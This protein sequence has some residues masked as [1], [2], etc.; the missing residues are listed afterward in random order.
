MKNLNKNFGKSYSDVYDLIYKD[1]NYYKE[2]NLISRLVVKHSKILESKNLLD[3]GCGTGAHAYHLSK[4]YNIVGI[5]LSEEM[6]R[7]AAAKFDGSHA[8]KTP[9]FLKDN[10][11]TFTSK[12]KFDVA[13]MMFSVVGY[14]LEIKKIQECLI[15]I[16]KH[17]K[18]SGVLI[19]DFWYGP[20]VLMQPPKDRVQVYK[21]K[22]LEVIRATETYLDVHRSTAS[23]N[24]TV[25]ASDGKNIIF[26]T[27]ET[28]KVRYFSIGEWE[29]LLGNS[30]FEVAEVMSFPG[31][32]GRLTDQTRT[33][34]IAARAI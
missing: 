6:L 8:R 24:F 18:K 3:I 22:N 19:F 31:G 11:V 2:C 12:L 26:Q 16:R 27:R 33:A 29:A 25:W 13:I 20:T 17:L 5:D 21:S 10:A 4:K 15:N 14:I 1:K 28:H 9:I 32:S 34:L 30:G 7:I 23:V